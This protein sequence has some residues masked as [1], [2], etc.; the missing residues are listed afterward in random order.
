MPK[1]NT[2]HDLFFLILLAAL[3]TI[4]FGGTANAAAGK[5]DFHKIFLSMPEYKAAQQQY[6]KMAQQKAAEYSR[7]MANAKDEQTKQQ[8]KQQ[9]ET[10][11]TQTK[12]EIMTPVVNKAKQVIN[13]VAAEKKLEHIYNS[14]SSE[15]SKAEKDITA[16]VIT[17]LAQDRA[18]HAAD[19]T[20][21]PAKAE[22]KPQPK[23]VQT[24][25]AKPAPFAENKLAKAEAPAK[26][27]KTQIKQPAKA[28]KPQ[29]KPQPVPA[30]GGERIIQFGADTT[31]DEMRQW[32]AKAKKNGIASAYLDEIVNSKGRKWWRARVAAN[33]KAEADA[34]CEKL[35]A[36][37][38]KYYIVKQ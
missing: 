36:I 1:T 8:M 27:E 16:D 10:W 21:Q 14:Q 12:I 34:I 32:V 13:Q 3:L 23:P 26:A 30:F 17:R 4:P 5:A 38:L 6:S 37:G 22:A 20:K 7:L 31:P 25:K 24:V 33:S 15:A 28:E 19:G 35:K 11:R 18:R 9:H 29:V 2:R